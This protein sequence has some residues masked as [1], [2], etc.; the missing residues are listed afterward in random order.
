MR[1]LLLMFVAIVF[2]MPLISAEK[3]SRDEVV[4]AYIYQLSDRVDWPAQSIDGVFGIHIIEKERRFSRSFERAVKGE[5]LKGVPIRVSRSEDAAVPLQVQVVFVDHSMLGIY[6]KLFDSVEG[7]PVLIISDSYT[8]PKQMMINLFENEKKQL[9]FQINKANIIN[10]NLAVDPDIILLGGTEIDVAKLYRES[11]ETL[12]SRE[13]RLE[14]LETLNARLNRQTEQAQ[15]EV[16]R[17]Q[18]MIDTQKAE[19]SE[20]TKKLEQTLAE[21]EKQSKTV[22]RQSKEIVAQKRELGAAKQRLERF[23]REVSALQTQ[24]ARQKAEYDKLYAESERQKSD[25]AKR[26]KELESQ[27]VEIEKRAAILEEQLGRIAEL[28]DTI[29][30][31][32]T[33]ISK[34]T[35]TIETQVQ[36]L[37]LLAAFVILV[38]VFTVYF[39]KSR[40]RYKLLSSE[41]KTAKEAADYA[42]R[43]KSVFLANMSHELRTPLNAIMGFSE[44]LAKNGGLSSKQSES[45]AIINRSGTHLLTLINDI[46][47]LSK[48]EAGQIPLEN[49][50]LDLH[51]LVK[52]TL[53]LVRH[54]AEMKG[55][56]LEYDQ[57]PQLPQ[58]IVCDANKVRQILINFL[59]NA[60]KY[61]NEGG[62]VLL[63]EAHNGMLHIEVRDSGV[64][65]DA[66]DLDVVFDPFT[67][68]GSASAKTGTGLGL[69]I[70]KQFAQL[71]GG[72]VGVTSEPG[73]GSVF[74]AKVAYSDAPEHEV[75]AVPEHE[76]KLR[77]E[78]VGLSESQKDIKVLIVEDQA[79]NRLL[80]RSILDVLGLQVKEAVD[81]KEAVE[82]F[83]AWQPDFVWMDRRM[84]VMGGEEATRR[85]RKLPGG[86]KCVIVA[87]TASAFH[88]ERDTIMGAGMDDYIAKPYRSY[89]IFDCMQKHLG[90]DYIYREMEPSVKASVDY[91]PEELAAALSGLDAALRKRLREVTIIL[92]N[93]AMEP[94]LEE[95]RQY[96]VKLSDA[97]STMAKQFQ[98]NVILRALESLDGSE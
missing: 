80:L 42:N 41:L 40:R 59:S 5:K 34:Q 67:Q 50:V 93:K 71:M 58:Y 38:L 69:A 63:V 52:E 18:K 36:T 74:W 88:E 29:K 31:Q 85:I 43:S 12:R 13:K 89:E 6:T 17:L 92:D 55:L 11:Q 4:S 48:I 75:A 30:A 90:L 24:I 64:G 19:I 16:L 33:Q 47:S 91:T 94:V 82:I 1:L 79:D 10:Q 14:S 37:Y 66:K 53:D 9:H 70:T 77:K 49:G 45:L 96:N 95:I 81:G 26:S 22:T 15:D 46:L 7:R 27:R 32:E 84:P 2:A 68:V 20:R 23:D 21:I 51:R 25:I 86:E 72:S 97:L 83:E 54:R 3:L 35:E 73:K 28:D 98:H 87:L 60:V 8:N 76:K 39:F 78:V 44:I 57:L 61:T 65:I 56:S 62:A